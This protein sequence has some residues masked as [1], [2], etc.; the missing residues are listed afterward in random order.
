MFYGTPRHQKLSLIK[1]RCWPRIMILFTSFSSCYFQRNFPH[2]FNHFKDTQFLTYIS[3]IMLK[4]LP[5]WI[6]TNALGVG[7]GGNKK[8]KCTLEVFGTFAPCCDLQ[9]ISQIWAC[10]AN[11]ILLAS[12][13]WNAVVILWPPRSFLPHSGGDLQLLGA[14]MWPRKLKAHEEIIKENTVNTTIVLWM[15]CRGVVSQNG[16]TAN[17]TLVNCR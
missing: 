1:K 15:S 4:F 17:S 7:R 14:N 2:F 9:F 11:Q 8:K 10:M 6:P 12:S 13:L 16:E 5:A 3:S